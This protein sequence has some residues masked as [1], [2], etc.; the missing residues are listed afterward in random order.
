MDASS[1]YINIVSNL[2]RSEM[3][4]GKFNFEILESGNNINQDDYEDDI[5]F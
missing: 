3:V 2:E 5:E 4:E 1:E